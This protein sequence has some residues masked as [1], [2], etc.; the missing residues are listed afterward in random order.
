MGPSLILGPLLRY[1]DETS[2]TVWVETGAPCEVTVELDAAEHRT[3]T[4]TVEGHHYA[5]VVV[6]GL[7][8]GSAHAYDVLLDGERVWPQPGSA[9]PRSVIRTSPGDGKL[10]LVFGSCRVSVPHHEPYTKKKG[11]VKQVTNSK[12]EARWAECVEAGDGETAS[13]A[14]L[15]IT[16]HTPCN[17][18]RVAVGMG[19]TLHQAV[20]IRSADGTTLEYADGTALTIGK[21]AGPGARTTTRSTDTLTVWRRLHLEEDRMGA[22]D[23]TEGPV[24]ERTFREGEATTRGGQAIAWV[25]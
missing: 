19:D 1:A 3:R 24:N 11:F 7:E 16:E 5:L 18:W 6:A 4:F 22:V 13:E 10:D 9:Y 21:G 20:K 12:T 14:F 2:A 15:K 25:E 23:F 17:N 8:P